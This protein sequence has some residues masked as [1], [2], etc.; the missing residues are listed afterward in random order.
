MAA[1]L[2]APETVDYAV[3]TIHTADALHDLASQRRP[4]RPG[5]WRMLV[6]SLR[7][8]TAH[9]APRTLSYYRS[10]HTCEAPVDL[11]ARQYPTLCIQAYAGI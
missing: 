9:R 11:L 4:V 8:S 1:V 5:F 6:Q 10:V 7:R 3:D 2:D